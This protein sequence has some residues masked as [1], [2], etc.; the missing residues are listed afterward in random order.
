MKSTD[1]YRVL[2]AGV[3][4][5]AKANGFKR[6]K[7][8]MLAYQRPTSNNK[9]ITFWFQCDKWGWDKYSG[10]RFTA[11]FQ[12]HE[13]KELGHFD[14]INHRF[15][16]FLSRE[17]LDWVR[18]M[19]NRIIS[20]VPPPPT[21]WVAQMENHFHQYS[22]NTEA[23]MEAFLQPWKLVQEPYPLSYDIWLRYWLNED[24]QMW[25]SF[26]L[27]IFPKA[28]AELDAATSQEMPFS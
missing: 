20:R 6:V 7:S 21:E 12:V 18:D 28:I 19:Q 16:H 10:S 26:F 1:V 9:F 27:E 3:G 24:V 8:G 25:A 22:R 11:E 13:S 15:S 17:Q 23:M 2:H 5:L 4:P 14:G